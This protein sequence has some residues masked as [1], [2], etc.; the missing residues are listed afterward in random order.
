MKRKSLEKAGNALKN[1]KDGKSPEAD[2]FSA[3]FL[4]RLGL[5]IIRS[6]NDA[7]KNKATFLSQKEVIVTSLMV[8]GSENLL[9]W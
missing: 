5:L 3:V 6:L 8:T 4:G 9:K 1:M 7:F 2:G